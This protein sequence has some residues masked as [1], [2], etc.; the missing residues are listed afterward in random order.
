MLQK[1]IKALQHIKIAIQKITTFYKK[2]L[3]TVQN[4][5]DA[6]KRGFTNNIFQNRL[7]K[8]WIFLQ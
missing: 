1:C 7:Q 4:N 2:M 8:P 3:E 6:T 5:F